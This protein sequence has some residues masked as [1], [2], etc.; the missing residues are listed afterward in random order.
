MKKIKITLLLLVAIAFKINAQ[1][2]PDHK[3][4]TR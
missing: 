3:K 2:H 4:R 1:E